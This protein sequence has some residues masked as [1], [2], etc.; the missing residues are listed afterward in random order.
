ML[1]P[2]VSMRSS[3]S[4]CLVLSLD[5]AVVCVGHCGAADLDIGIV[6]VSFWMT[7]RL[8]SKIDSLNE[9]QF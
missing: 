9:R 6:P 7:R 1:K 2:L 3:R 5:K 4:I 8:T